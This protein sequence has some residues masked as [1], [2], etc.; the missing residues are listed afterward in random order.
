MT[1][2]DGRT[3]EMADAYFELGQPGA[4]LDS[5]PAQGSSASITLR[6]FLTR[7]E[8]EAQTR[9][10]LGFPANG[11]AIDWQG[12]DQV[13]PKTD[14]S[15]PVSTFFSNDEDDKNKKSGKAKV[16]WL[17]SFIGA[18]KETKPDAASLSKLSVNLKG[19][20]TK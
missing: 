5:K 4:K 19:K 16:S 1:F 2:K 14:W 15:K 13:A 9:Q 6:S 8:P 12:R 11:K 10:I 7:A 20:D 3:A 18:D 17:T